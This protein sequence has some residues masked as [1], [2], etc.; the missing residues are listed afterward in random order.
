MSDLRHSVKVV[1][2]A[3]MS[4]L[5]ASCST[6]SHHDEQQVAER[7][8]Q[9]PV[10]KAPPDYASRLPSHLNVREK[11]VYVDPVVHAWGAYDSQGNL[12]KAGIATAGSDWCPDLGRPC[13]T[14]PG[15]FRVNSLGSPN[16]KSSMFPMPHGGAPMPYC[17]FFFGGYALHGSQLPGKPS[18]HGC[19]GIF[20]NDAR[21]LNQDFIKTGAN[22]TRIDVIS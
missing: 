21:W 20:D 12:V 8:V 6:Y 18:S 16:C 11:T 19:V 15:S 3:L 1:V 14:K 2:P 22:G 17:M 10:E 4:L 7:D 9:R 5:L 13:H